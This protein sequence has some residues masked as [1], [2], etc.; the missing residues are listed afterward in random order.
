ME[1]RDTRRRKL[2]E[3]S[4]LLGINQDKLLQV[5][6]MVKR[7]SPEEMVLATG[8][9]L[10]KSSSSRMLNRF[11]ARVGEYIDL[12]ATDGPDVRVWF[13]SITKVWT[14]LL[15]DYTEGYPRLLLQLPRS[16]RENPWSLVAYGDEITPGNVMDPDNHR[17]AFGVTFTLK[18]FGPKT[19]CH[20]EAWLPWCVIR[21]IQH[22][23]IRGGMSTVWRF[24][25]RHVFVTQKAHLGV[26]CGRLGTVYINLA[27]LIMDGDAWHLTYQM[28]ASKALVP[29][30]CLNLFQGDAHGIWRHGAPEA[31][32]RPLAFVSAV[33]L[34]LW[35]WRTCRGWGHGGAACRSFG[36]PQGLRRWT[37]SW[38]ST[39]RT[40]SSST[41]RP[42]RISGRRLTRL[43]LLGTSS[44]G[45]S[46][47]S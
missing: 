26:A 40:R 28:F 22:H 20:T 10:S 37:A 3:T 30:T 19:L 21:S 39:A 7:M 41:S 17:K 46:S 16:T 1:Q 32:P 18:D 43:R 4:G 13:V 12:P 29:C 23:K 8:R 33:Y 5:L 11:F 45:K 34:P 31:P 2:L 14:L 27:N 6:H 15:E 24:L 44:P 9:G 36:L 25:L 38:G 47:R 42:T 35:C